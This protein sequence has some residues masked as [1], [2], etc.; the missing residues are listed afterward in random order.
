MFGTASSPHPSDHGASHLTG[1]LDE[2]ASS[3]P[4]VIW[5]LYAGLPRRM[6]PFLPGEPTGTK[7]TKSSLSTSPALRSLSRTEA[8][9]TMPCPSVILRKSLTLPSSRTNLLQPRPLI[10]FR[11][12]NNPSPATHSVSC[13]FEESTSYITT[14]SN[15]ENLLT[16]P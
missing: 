14:S 13:H 3:P 9:R 12:V 10:S 15:N 6:T 5:H 4:P 7:G 11:N 1:P 2:T 16:P 8:K